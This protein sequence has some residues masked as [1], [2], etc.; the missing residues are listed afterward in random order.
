[1]P[2]CV[3]LMQTFTPLDHSHY[4]ALYVFG[5]SKSF[6]FALLKGYDMKEGSC[7]TVVGVFH[8]NV[9]NT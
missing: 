9:R 1:M 2:A 8:R 6:L 3:F 7:L 5:L 4:T